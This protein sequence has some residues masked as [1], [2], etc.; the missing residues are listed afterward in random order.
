MG[1]WWEQ[2]LNKKI[3][4]F[5][6]DGFVKYGILRGIE[7][8]FIVLEFADGAMWTVMRGDIADVKIDTGAG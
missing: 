3:V 2:L 6:T 5:K 1:I 7:E 8:K 4:V